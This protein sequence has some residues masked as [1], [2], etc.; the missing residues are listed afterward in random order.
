MYAWVVEELRQLRAENRELQAR[1]AAWEEWGK[2]LRCSWD[3]DTTDLIDEV[4][5]LLNEMPDVK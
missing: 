2:R 5:R 1:L 4:Q 3:D